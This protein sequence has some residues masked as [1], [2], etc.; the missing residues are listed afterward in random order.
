MRLRVFIRYFDEDKQKVSRLSDLT[1]D[2]CQSR[3]GEE[4]LVV[5]DRVLP[6]SQTRERLLS[7]IVQAFSFGHG[8]M[9]APV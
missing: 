6:S 5:V 1:E 7:S 9:L 8:I 4:F 2:Y 3:V